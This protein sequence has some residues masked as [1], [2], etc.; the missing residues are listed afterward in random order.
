M[1]N[2]ICI[3]CDKV[4]AFGNRLNHSTFKFSIDLNLLNLNYDWWNEVWLIVKKINIGM[5]NYVCI[6]AKLSIKNL[7][8]LLIYFENVFP[9]CVLWL[10]MSI[11][12]DGNNIKK[13]WFEV[14]FGNKVRLIILIITSI[15]SSLILFTF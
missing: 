12:H 3:L 6:K 14:I 1:N 10:L 2:M 7:C 5:I 8:L 9:N 4:L 15:F 13:N 11:F